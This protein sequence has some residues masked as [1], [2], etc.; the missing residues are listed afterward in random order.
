[1]GVRLTEAPLTRLFEDAQSTAEWRERGFHPVLN[2]RVQ[3]AEANLDAGVMA[4]LLQLKK[5]NPLPPGALLPDSFDLSLN[6]KQQCAK[7]E[8]ID[9]HVSKYPLWGMPFAL[10]GI[11]AQEQDLLQK[12]LQD[13]ARMAP[14][15]GLPPAW[16]RQVERWEQFLNGDS[17]K[18]QLMA[19]YIYEHWF[20]ARLYFDQLPPQEFFRIVRSSTPPGEPIERIATRRPFDDPGVKRVFY[21][22]WREQGT[23]LDKTHMP[24][25]LN[26]QRME[27]IQS[28][29]LD[30]EY[31]LDTLPSY[32]PEVAANPFVAYEA[33]PVHSR[34]SFLLEEAQFTIN[35]FIKGPVCR[36]QIALNVINDHFW[37]FF[38]APKIER[39]L[40][41]EHFLAEQKHHLRMPVEKGSTVLPIGTWR[42]YA[43]SQEK[44][45]E[46]KTRSLEEI[47]RNGEH[48]TLDLVWDGFG[49]NPNA[50]LTVF[51]HFDSASVVQGLVGDPPKTAWVID[52]ALL[53]RIHYLLVAGFDVYGNMGH[54]LLTRL[55]MDFLRMEGE[56]NF[57]ALLPQETRLEMSEYWYRK[58]SERQRSYV[59][60]SRTEFHEPTGIEYRTDDPRLELFDMLKRRLEPVL[61]DDYS[62]DNYLVP[63]QH[64]APL[65]RL[66]GLRGLAVA[67]LPQLVFLTVVDERGLDWQYT[68]LHNNA[69]ANI[70]SLF[71]EDSLRLPEED[72]VT[73]VRGFMGSYPGAFW[74]VSESE[75][76]ELVDAA[77]GLD[78]EES[79]GKLM[80]RFGVRRTSPDFWEHS[81]R[82]H[83][84]YRQLAPATG[85]L[86]D[87]NRLE[88]R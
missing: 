22:L 69:H 42:Q 86:L 35:N 7:A 13:G 23:V 6:R 50:A 83:A 33:L 16:R 65:K 3:S 60:G 38:V 2:E 45:L 76:D 18:Q 17:L 19:R 39:Q 8:E 43:K 63:A 11:P 70:T 24:Y 31:E 87:Y 30:A 64:R 82:V 73:V 21:R 15:P 81:D 9:F 25:A 59:F 48:L 47:F 80:D 88:N 40:E 36:G 34:W 49:E 84:R 57:L 5:E 20:L 85:G 1:L 51:R 54:Q 56:F 12:W 28:W 71:A 67:P 44:Y 79:Y 4:R 77:A 32:A 41:S 75:L 10:P 62:L 66:A 58:A 72:D 26:D 52:Y 78:G 53:E 55:Y 61:A 68:V 14:R 29:F 74:K 27:K 46:A 37:V